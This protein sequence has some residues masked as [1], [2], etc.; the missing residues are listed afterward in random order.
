MATRLLPEDACKRATESASRSASSLSDEARPCVSADSS[1]EGNGEEA[2]VLAAAQV[3][4]QAQAS[5]L[6]QHVQQNEVLLGALE[7]RI[8]ALDKRLQ[9]LIARSQQKRSRACCVVS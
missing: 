4:F 9:A 7:G 1:Q 8:A 3:S 5:D 6:A 2:S